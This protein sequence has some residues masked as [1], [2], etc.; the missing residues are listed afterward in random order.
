MPR[1][2]T[3]T[4]RHRNSRAAQGLLSR[5]VEMG[6]DLLEGELLIKVTYFEA[7]LDV[8][9]FRF[10]DIETALNSIR[11]FYATGQPR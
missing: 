2:I 5:S 4:P 3:E 8:A 1:A 10:D 11:Q 9:M 6:D 7:G